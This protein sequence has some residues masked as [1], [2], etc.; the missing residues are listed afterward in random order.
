[1]CPVVEFAMAR[2]A[3]PPNLK[4]LRIIIVVSVNLHLC[5]ANLTSRRN[6]N[7]SAL[8]RFDKDMA[9]LDP[10][11]VTLSL[12]FFVMVMVLAD[13]AFPGAPGGI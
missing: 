2:S 3:K 13:A 1:M 10:L 8:L 5:T 6:N 11:R 12:N 7:F 9:A 4:R